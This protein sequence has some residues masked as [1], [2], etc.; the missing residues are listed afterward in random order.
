MPLESLIVRIQEVA[1]AMA[2]AWSGLV[3]FSAPPHGVFYEVI[4]T[5]GEFKKRFKKFDVHLGD[6]AHE[7]QRLLI[8]E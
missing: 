3:E 7:I 5:S 2:G 4:V 8:G 6:Q 1:Q